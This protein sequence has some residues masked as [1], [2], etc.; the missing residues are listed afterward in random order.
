M[1]T[2]VAVKPGALKNA[3]KDARMCVPMIPGRKEKEI[4]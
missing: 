3:I 2:A 1:S 4:P